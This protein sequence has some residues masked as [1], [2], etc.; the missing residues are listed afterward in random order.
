MTPSNGEF[1]AGAF[2]LRGV[3]IPATNGSLYYS[4]DQKVTPQEMWVE[5]VETPIEAVVLGM[6]AIIQ[7]DSNG[8][9]SVAIVDSRGES[10]LPL[11]TPATTIV[12]IEGNFWVGTQNGVHVFGRNTSG[13]CV[14]MGSIELAGPI[15][16]LI[17]LFDGSAAFVSEV[18]MVG[19]IEQSQSVVA[20]E[21]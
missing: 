3:S 21:Q 20:L 4:F 8:D 15:V 13:E 12:A 10:I 14:E 6:V 19:I 18:G 7:K 17:P 5:T 9:S 11:P 16:Q 1:R 2:D